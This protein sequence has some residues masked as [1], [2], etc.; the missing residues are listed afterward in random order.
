M[1]R[2][3]ITLVGSSNV[4]LVVKSPRM[5]VPGETILGGITKRGQVRIRVYGF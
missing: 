4:D 3:S 2:S 5:P 1:G